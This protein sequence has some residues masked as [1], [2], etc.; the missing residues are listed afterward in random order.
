MTGAGFVRGGV[1][2][3]RVGYLLHDL[4]VTGINADQWSIKTAAQ[5]KRE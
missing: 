3:V 4:I 1:E 5:G 2:K